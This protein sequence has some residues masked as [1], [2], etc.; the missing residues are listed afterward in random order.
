MPYSAFGGRPPSRKS[1]WRMKGRGTVDMVFA[2]RFLQEQRQEQNKNPYITIVDLTK[3]FDTVSCE[4]QWKIMA[5][6]GCLEK[7]ISMVRKF[8]D[9]MLS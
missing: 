1:L 4:G 7:F 9:C 6:F 5:T 3:A 2:T 8:H